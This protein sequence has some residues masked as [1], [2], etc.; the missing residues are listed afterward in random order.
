MIRKSVAVAVFA[1]AFGVFFLDN[2]YKLETLEWV[3]DILGPLLV[4]LSIFLWNP[5]M[6][7]RN[8]QDNEERTEDGA[9]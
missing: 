6:F 7:S 3:P 4:V 5:E 8:Q 2:L 9:P 1:L